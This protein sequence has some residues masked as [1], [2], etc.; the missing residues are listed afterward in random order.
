MG[1]VWFMKN[2]TTQTLK[3]YNERLGRPQSKVRSEIFA[4]SKFILNSNQWSDYFNDLDIVMGDE[5]NLDQL[6]RYS[7]YRSKE[8]GYH[9]LNQPLSI[10]SRQGRL[11]DGVMKIHYNERSTGKRVALQLK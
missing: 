8:M 5:K 6:L 9:Q 10:L 2:T 4:K 1:Q 11:R 7:V 3:G